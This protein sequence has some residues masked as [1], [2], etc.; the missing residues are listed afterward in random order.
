MRKRHGPPPAADA[1]AKAPFVPRLP[2]EPVINWAKLAQ[3][4]R[5]V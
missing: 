3:F 1:V 2:D 5:W 4:P